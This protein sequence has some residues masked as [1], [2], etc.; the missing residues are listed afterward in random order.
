[1]RHLPALQLLAGLTIVLIAALAFW[2]GDLFGAETIEIATLTGIVGLL[3]I[4]TSR[5]RLLR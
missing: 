2:S 5:V 4:G 3:L 1:M